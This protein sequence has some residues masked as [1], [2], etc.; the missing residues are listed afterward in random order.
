MLIFRPRRSLSPARP[1][2]S[3]PLPELADDASRTPPISLQTS[4]S[5]IV[6]GPELLGLDAV[7][8]P[9]GRLFFRFYPVSSGLL[10]LTPWP[11]S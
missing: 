1:F 11:E 3:T 8:G 6:A 4:L 7:G 5:T 9:D 2:S 10:A